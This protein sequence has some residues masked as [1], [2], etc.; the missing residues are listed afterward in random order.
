[1]SYKNERVSNLIAT[2]KYND[3]SVPDLLTTLIGRDRPVK[4]QLNVA[5]CLTYLHRANALSS[6]DP[7]VSMKTM[8]VYG[9]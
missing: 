6:T 8:Y 1:M 7:R 4:M 9:A 3:T 5:R 2:S